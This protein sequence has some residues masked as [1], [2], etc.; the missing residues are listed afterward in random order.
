MPRYD[1]I[2]KFEEMVLLTLV[3]LGAKA[4]GVSIREEIKDRTGRNV[5]YAAVYQVL[6]RLVEKGYAS[7]RTGERTSERGGRAKRYFRIEAPGLRALAAERA[8]MD[9]LWAGVVTSGQA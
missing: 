6:E 7:S 1:G 4:Y 8:A 2:D 3:H 5:S 9:H